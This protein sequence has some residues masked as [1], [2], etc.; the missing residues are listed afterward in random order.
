EDD[1]ALGLAG[2]GERAVV[3]AAPVVLGLPAVAAVEGEEPV[4]SPVWITRA[5][6]LPL[7]VRAAVLTRPSVERPD[8]NSQLLAP[9]VLTT[10]PPSLTMAMRPDDVPDPDQLKL[11]DTAMPWGSTWTGEASIRFQSDAVRG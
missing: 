7:R 8:P 2:I 10:D 9:L 6:F 5:G 1:E 4:V 11:P 3:V